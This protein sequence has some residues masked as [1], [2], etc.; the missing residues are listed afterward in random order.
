MRDNN[1]F[2]NLVLEEF[3]AININGKELY[4]ILTDNPYGSIK[5][6]L[7]RKISLED[8]ILCNPKDRQIDLQ[9]KAL[10]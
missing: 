4:P 7:T 9:T 10:L 2:D 3:K 8:L 5:C 1:K 6:Y